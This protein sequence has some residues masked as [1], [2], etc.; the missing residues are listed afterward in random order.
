MTM[1]EITTSV[2]VR[3]VPVAPDDKIIALPG[4]AVSVQIARGYNSLIN[5]YRVD[6]QQPD[7]QGG[8]LPIQDPPLASGQV[9]P[10]NLPP[11]ASPAAAGQVLHTVG[12][13]A[14]LPGRRLVVLTGSIALP[15]GTAGQCDVIIA[16]YQATGATYR[17]VEWE[18]DS[19]PDQVELLSRF[20]ITFN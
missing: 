4:G 2:S 13:P 6:L 10:L 5:R 3:D 11:G 16:L 19:A 18:A 15:P 14:A 7:G 8:W 12:M 9:P 1:A 20:T 17:R